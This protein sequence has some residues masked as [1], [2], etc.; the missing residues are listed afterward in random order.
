MLMKLS[1]PKGEDVIAQMSEEQVDM[2]EWLKEND[3]MIPE[4]TFKEVSIKYLC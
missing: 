2:L 4:F 3:A 1:L